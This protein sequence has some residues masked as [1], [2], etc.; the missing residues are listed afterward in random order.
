[1]YA[2]GDPSHLNPREM[3]LPT[4]SGVPEFSLIYRQDD[5]TIIP[6]TR[7][8]ILKITAMFTCQKNYFNT[9]CNIY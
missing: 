5:A 9:A 7:K 1:M 8:Q 6:Y 3:N 2:L 4:S